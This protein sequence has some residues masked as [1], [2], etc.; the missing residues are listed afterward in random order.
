MINTKNIFKKILREWGHDILYQR[1]ISDD[2]KYCDT[3]ER[4]TTRSRLPRAAK[5]ALSLEENTEGYFANADLVYYF[6]ANVNPKSG[7]RIYEES[8][9]GYENTIIYKIDDAYG[10]RGRF[11]EITYWLVGATKEQPA[12]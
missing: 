3:L 1:R 12:G 7:D 11:G 9:V 2:F 6:E 4:I 5:I 10:V 8:P